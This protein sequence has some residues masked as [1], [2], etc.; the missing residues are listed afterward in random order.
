MLRYHYNIFFSHNVFSSWI[1]CLY[2]LGLEAPLTPGEPLA[3]RPPPP[4]GVL[5][6]AGPPP[7]PGGPPPP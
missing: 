4:P 5:R 3:P 1:H 7:I 2:E 6:V